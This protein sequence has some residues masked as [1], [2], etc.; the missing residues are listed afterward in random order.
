[1]II[2]KITNK[3]NSKSYIGQTIFT[4]KRRINEHINIS[5]R[6]DGYVIHK[7]IKNADKGRITLSAFINRLASYYKMDEERNTKPRNILLSSKS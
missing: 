5:N 1:M 2:Y 7:A 6:N 4:L 3:I